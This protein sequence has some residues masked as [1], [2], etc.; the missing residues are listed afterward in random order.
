MLGAGP[1][2]AGRHSG[3]ALGSDS[4]KSQGTDLLVGRVRGHLGWTPRQGLPGDLS[5]WGSGRGGEG[6]AFTEGVPR[7]EVGGQVGGV[8]PSCSPYCGLT[9]VKSSELTLLSLAHQHLPQPLSCAFHTGTG[10]DILPTLPAPVSS[11]AKWENSAPLTG[12]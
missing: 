12:L 2:V 8:W 7:Y 9:A 10:R 3:P 4:N 6:W 5:P 1:W 11:S